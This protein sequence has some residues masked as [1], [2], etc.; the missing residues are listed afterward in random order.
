[1][2]LCVDVGES[3]LS[4][5]RHPVV[6]RG[7]SAASLLASSAVTASAAWTG[8]GCVNLGNISRAMRALVSSGRRIL[9]LSLASSL[10]LLLGRVCGLSIA[11]EVYR[12][13]LVARLPVEAT[14]V[15][16]GL[17]VRRASPERSLRR[18]TVAGARLARVG[19]PAP[20]APSEWF[21]STTNLHI[22]PSMG[23][24]LTCCFRAA[25]CALGS[26][27]GDGA[28]SDALCW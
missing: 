18:A 21:R 7:A 27:F 25:F 22:W 5:L 12:S 4:C 8:A 15:A 11:L 19:R 9:I 24:L 28:W 3:E 26:W 23:A 16:D 10:T 14:G 17:A 2:P 1:M 13:V 20:R 6:V